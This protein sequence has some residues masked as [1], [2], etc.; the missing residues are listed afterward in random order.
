MRYNDH[1]PLTT[2]L[3]GKLVNLIERVTGGPED[4]QTNPNWSISQFTN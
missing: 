2:K 3:T 1:Y 4:W